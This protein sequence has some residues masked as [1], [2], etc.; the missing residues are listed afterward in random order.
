V[1]V[2]VEKEEEE[3]EIYNRRISDL[4]VHRELS[5]LLIFMGLSP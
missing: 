2:E 3:E 1:S 5:C 4:R